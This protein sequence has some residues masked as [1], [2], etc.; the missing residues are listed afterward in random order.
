MGSNRVAGRTRSYGVT[1]ID[2]GEPSRYD[3]GKPPPLRR[4]LERWEPAYARRVASALLTMVLAGALAGTAP[5]A[6][7]LPELHRV[8]RFV[9]S[10]SVF[11]TAD[12]VLNATPDGQTMVA[13]GLDG[14]GEKWR[15]SIGNVGPIR[16][17]AS[18]GNV[19]VLA[20]GLMAVDE[21]ASFYWESVVAVDVRTGKGVWQREEAPVFGGSDLVVVRARSGALAGVAI[22]SGREVWRTDLPDG[23]QV[24]AVEGSA[25]DELVALRPGGTIE[26]ITTATGAVT[27]TWRVARPAKGLTLAWRDLV[28]LQGSAESSPAGTSESGAG[29]GTGT[30]TTARGSRIEVFRRGQAGALWHL[31]FPTTDFFVYPCA[32]RWFCVPAGRI[33]P[34]T[35]AVAAPLVVDEPDLRHTRWEPLGEYAGHRLVWLDPVWAADS[36]MWLGV[37]RPGEQV[38]PLMPLGGRANSCILIG[39]WL[40]CDGSAV[41]DAV[42]VRLSDLDGLLAEVG[43]PA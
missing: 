10:P 37:V 33:D 41:V 5:G 17:V 27:K 6:E 23:A 36:Q 7:P 28:V 31:D 43:G 14:S 16:V 24:V 29:S 1:L 32:D 4:L 19:V 39:N 42:S 9:A 21:E 40:Y 38:H 26:V 35:G 22:E 20:G 13:S 3:P 8:G 15:R 30:F 18:A 25:D 34:Y 12:V 11:A 2:L